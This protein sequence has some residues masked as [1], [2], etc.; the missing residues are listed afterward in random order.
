[1]RTL[2]KY[3]TIFIEAV[4]ICLVLFQV[5]TAGFGMKVDI[6]QRSVHLGFVLLLVFLLR[7]A[8]KKLRKDKV[9]VYDLILAILAVI[10][11][12][13]AAIKWPVFINNPMNWASPIDKTLAILTVVLVLEASRRSVGWIFPI[14]AIFFFLYTRFGEICPGIWRHKDF[15]IDYIFQVFYHTTSGM[16]GQM[17]SISSTML[18]MFGIFGAMLSCTGG[19]STFIKLGQK[20]T[21]KSIGGSG[22]VCIVASG[23]FG[24]I[25][26]SAAANIVATGTF[27]IPM[28]KESK[29]SNEWA[30]SIAAVASTGGQ[31]MPPIMGAAAFIMSQLTGVPYIRIAVCAIIPALLYYLSTFIATHYFSK[32]LNIGGVAT[33]V[34]INFAEYF[35]IFAPIGVFLYLL[36]RGYSVTNA[37]FYATIVGIFAT[38]AVYFLAGT[39]E[40]RKAAPK[41]TVNLL[42]KTAHGGAYSILDMATILSGAQVV[43]TLITTSGFAVKLSDVIVR[44]GQNNLFLC[45]I[46]SM[47]VC[48]VLGMGVPTTAAYVLGSAILC[49]ALMSLGLDQFV[50]HMFVFYFACLSA[51]TPPVC[52]AVFL[53]AGMA[54]AN[55]LKTGFLSCLIALPIFIVPY[56]FVY[57][58]ALLLNSSDILDT[59]VAVATAVVGVFGMGIGTAGYFKRFMPM[60]IRCALFASGLMLVVPSTLVSV[61]GLVLFVVLIINET[62]KGKNPPMKESAA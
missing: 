1:M 62:R 26:G 44:V 34:K 9:P 60:F 21:G 38:I 40:E 2:N 12:G 22:K 46:L 47:I 23:L 56:T 3:W 53:G 39:K 14:L 4:C 54:N 5:Y 37:A 13:Y 59:V 42:H 43:I 49:P 11:C 19:A 36:I 15:T 61:I 20:L 45:L 55:W 57:D 24:M 51:I 18:A 31:I 30:A 32:G 28:M 35:I 58:Q 6:F 50:A 41:K 29:Y 16:W 10:C 8:S 33:K 48:L 7:P 17:L 52:T 27:T 25:S